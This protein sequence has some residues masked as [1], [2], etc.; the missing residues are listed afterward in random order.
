M[1]FFF[2]S[3]CGCWSEFSQVLNSLLAVYECNSGDCLFLVLIAQR[4]GVTLKWFYSKNKT[5][6]Y[7]LKNNKMS[8]ARE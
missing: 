2:S 7:A 6:L 8:I 3:P 5:F 1:M 4:H